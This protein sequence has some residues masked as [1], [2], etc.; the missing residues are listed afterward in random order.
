[1]HANEQ[2]WG[3]PPLSEDWAWAQWLLTITGEMQDTAGHREVA[4]E[5][6]EGVEYLRAH[7]QGD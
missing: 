3:A 2:G 7:D 4:G 6:G 1:M 5:E